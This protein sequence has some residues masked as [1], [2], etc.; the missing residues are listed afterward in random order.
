MFNPHCPTP[1]RGLTYTNATASFS[2]IVAMPMYHKPRKIMSLLLQIWSFHSG[3][4]S[5]P[6]FLGCDAVSQHCT[7]SQPRKP[8]HEVYSS[9]LFSISTSVSK[10][11]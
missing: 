8:G 3:E 4:D 6:G 7:A 2:R 10:A 11:W 1:F 5:C 9:P